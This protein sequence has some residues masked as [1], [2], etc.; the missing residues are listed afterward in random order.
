MARKHRRR[1]TP[2]VWCFLLGFVLVGPGIT[3][4]QT[5]GWRNPAD[6]TFISVGVATM[7]VAV[8]MR[9]RERKRRLEG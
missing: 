9:I 7:T 1:T 6:F 5:D 8:F 4:A 2:A 3:G